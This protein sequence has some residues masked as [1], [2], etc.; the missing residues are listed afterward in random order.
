MK[1]SKKNRHLRNLVLLLIFS[2]FLLTRENRIQLYYKQISK[3]NAEDLVHFFVQD[4][5]VQDSIYM[6]SSS[7]LDKKLPKEE[8]IYLLVESK[9]PIKNLIIK[10][11]ILK[12]DSLNFNL[13][14]DNLSEK[15]SLKAYKTYMAEDKDRKHILSAGIEQRKTTY[16]ANLYL[17]PTNKEEV[18]YP[19]N[20]IK[21]KWDMAKFNQV[22]QILLEIYYTFDLKDK[23]FAKKTTIEFI[24]LVLNN[25]IWYEFLMR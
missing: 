16:T 11:C 22:E 5:E 19:K 8:L 25:Y 20:Y 18:F 14:I 2:F 24:P 12:I 9:K 7:Y 4:I 6:E 23:S 13:S 10:S 21:T 3:P 1:L 17:Y 15:I